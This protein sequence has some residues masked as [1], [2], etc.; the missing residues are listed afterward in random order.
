MSGGVQQSGPIDWHLSPGWESRLLNQGGLPLKQWLEN[1]QASIVKTGEHR[2]VYRVD[3]GDQSVYV[4]HYRCTSVG[5]A[6]RTLVRASAA[7]REFRK[8]R[9]VSRRRVPTAHAIGYGEQ[10]RHGLVLD[11]FF[12]TEALPGAIPLDTCVV[13][14]LSHYSPRSRTVLRHR[15]TRALAA[16]CAK[17]HSHGVVQDDL[18]AGNL[19]VTWEPPTGPDGS[20]PDSLHEAADRTGDRVLPWPRLHLIDLPGVR[21]TRPLSWRQTRNNLVMLQAGMI[22]VTSRTDRWRFWRAYL[23]H[24]TDLQLACPRRAAAEVATVARAFACRNMR[25]R[26]RRALRNNR[27]FQS[28]RW[29]RTRVHA[30]RSISPETLGE[31]AANPEAILAQF[32]HH[33][34][35]LSHTSVLVQAELIVDGVPTKIAWKRCRLVGGWKRW[36][37]PLRRSRALAS[38]YR[39]QALWQRAV[40]TARPLC[41]IDPP[42]RDSYLA[43]QWIDGAENLHLFAWRLAD[44]PR[45]EGERLAR[46]TAASLGQLIGNLHRWRI[47]HRDLKWGNL[48]AVQRGDQV[49]TA[50]I[51]LDGLRVRVWL[52]NRERARNLARLAASLVLHPRIRRSH[53]VR[54]LQA[55]V[56]T[57]E[58][59]SDWKALWKQVAAHSQA[60]LAKK[61]RRGWQRG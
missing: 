13:E 28:F 9:E 22:A 24:R 40:A 30:I 17:L 12:V 25:G 46:S 38:W 15:L 58:D 8:M 41:V 26:D 14:Y 55:Y 21:F 27:D 20:T 45:A 48:L 34:L 47:A 51:D 16:F 31:L 10:R 29:G 59:G 61:E 60:L 43:T 52:R 36:L 53:C 11:N 18:H 23:T 57:L 1:G 19:L 5:R 35:K 49:E 32:H 54:F 37:A 50:I 7:R 2:T 56:A 44:L 4:K 42:G 39:G 3:L 33:P 6:G